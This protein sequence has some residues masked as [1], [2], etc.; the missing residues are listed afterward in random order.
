MALMRLFFGVPL[1]PAATLALEAV[2][3]RLQ[4]QR[5]WRWVGAHNWHITLSF[6][7]DTDGKWVNALVDLGE[8]VA[9]ESVAGA[10]V[11]DS[12]QW[13][14]SEN[15][16]RLLAAVAEQSAAL[17]PIRKLLNAG[18]RELGL[19]FD[20]KPLRAHVTLLRLERGVVIDDLRL[21]PC[22]VHVAAD[23]IALYVSEK[24]AGGKRYRPIWE[25]A[26][27][28]IPTFNH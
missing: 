18:L 25:Q 4:T 8:R 10:L 20:G 12:L 24:A 9:Q 26:L 16:P 14:P 19:P 2:C 6:L 11:L 28:T 5:G 15:K 21:P 1:L 23:R 17:Q 27:I 13:W 22:A 3:T 7:G